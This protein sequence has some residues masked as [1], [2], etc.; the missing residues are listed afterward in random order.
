MSTKKE[1]LV[2]AEAL[3]TKTAIHE[4]QADFKEDPDA[5]ITAAVVQAYRDNHTTETIVTKALEELAEKAVS[6][7]DGGQAM[8]YAQASL[9]LAYVISTLEVGT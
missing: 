4:A 1:A 6:A 5:F 3:R 9:N 2:V 7:P 8:H